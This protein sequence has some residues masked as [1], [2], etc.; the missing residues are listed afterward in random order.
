MSN[1]TKGIICLLI[2]SLGFSIMGLCIKMSGELP[3]MQKAFFRNF[4]SMIVAFG[5]VLYNRVPMFGHRQNQKLLI[6]R[7]VFGVIGVILFFYSLDHLVLSDAEMLNK[8]S[9]FFTIILCSIFLNERIRKFQ[10]ISIIIAFIGTLFIIKPELSLEVVPSLI[11][12]LGAISA[13]SAYTILRVLGPLE[14]F[15]TV[16]FYFSMFS[17]IVLLPFVIVNFHPM[18][19]KQLV[20][21]ITAGL[22]ASIGQFGITLAYQ[23]AEAKQISIFFYSTV[24]FSALFSIIIFKT[25]PD[26]Y[27]IVGY[28]IVFSASF[29][30]FMKQRPR[31]PLHER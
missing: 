3:T 4:I 24:L 30:M 1:V 13:A 5:F 22:M 23:F 27:S 9:P 10:M 28:I 16:V 2:A 20:L 17:T 6:A 21:L 7:S 26:A 29:Y 18:S 19:T 15:Y 14:K 11:A 25:I 12:L 8:L 31:K